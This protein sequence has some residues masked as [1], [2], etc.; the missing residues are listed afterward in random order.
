MT[1]SEAD[2]HFISYWNTYHSFTNPVAHDLE[3]GTVYNHDIDMRSWTA[4]SNFLEEIF[5]NVNK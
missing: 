1:E 4:M 2:L 5:S 3:M